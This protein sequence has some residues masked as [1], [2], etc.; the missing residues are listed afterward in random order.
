MQCMKKHFLI[1]K[2][3]HDDERMVNET[4]KLRQQGTFEEV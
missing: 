1:V 4:T 3:D 2:G